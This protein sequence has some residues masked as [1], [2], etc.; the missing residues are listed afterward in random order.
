MSTRFPDDESLATQLHDALDSEAAMVTPSD[1]GLQRIRAGID[2]AH[3][4]WWR[5]PAAIAV[6]AAVVLGTAVGVG[7]AVLG[8]DNGGT[9]VATNSTTGG[10]TPSNATSTPAPTTASIQ[11]EP[12]DP[13]MTG[14]PRPAGDEALV[15]VYYVH[16]DGHG[17]RLYREQH[18]EMTAGNT[19][20]SGLAS[21]FG[22]PPQDPDYQSLWPG[23]TLIDY[24]AV[25]DIATVDLSA[26]PA[27]GSEAENAAV[28]ELVYT[29]TAND[30]SVKSVKLLVNGKTP[31]ANRRGTHFDLSKPISREPVLDV[32]GWIWLLGP[33]QGATVNSPVQISGYGTAFEGT[34]SWEV[35]QGGHKVAEG[36]TQGGSN[37]EFA[38]FSDTVDLPPGTYEIRAFESSA[39]DGSPQHVDTKTFTVR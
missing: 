39:K 8:G 2:V 30:S 16:D 35:R 17:P 18:S 27:L 4:P 15:Y 14:S 7:A 13:P 20:N 36:H 9:V 38:D 19:P 22:A 24:Q 34:I 11:P 12:Q 10:S 31:P 1:D 33:A 5:H 3:R 29:V 21:L 23:G 25:G 6:A 37:G 26:W 28:Q 32:Q